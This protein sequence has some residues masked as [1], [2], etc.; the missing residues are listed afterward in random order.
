[1]GD[2]SKNQPP[3]PPMGYAQHQH[4]AYPQQSGYPPQPGY[5]PQQGFQ[6]QGFQQQGFQ[7]QG[8]QQQGFM[9]PPAPTAAYGGVYTTQ[10]QNYAGKQDPES[11]PAGF[12]DSFEDKAVRRGFI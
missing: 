1:M 5:P 12:L 3:Y 8:F 10:E 2:S 6:Q 11:N 7:Q 9:P 4:P